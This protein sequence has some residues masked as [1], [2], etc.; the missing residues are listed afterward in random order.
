MLHVILRIQ[1]Q[2]LSLD[3][4]CNHLLVTDLPPDDCL[5]LVLQL[6][7]QLF[8]RNHGLLVHLFGVWHVLVVYF[9]IPH[10]VEDMLQVLLIDLIVFEC[11]V[12]LFVCFIKLVSKLLLLE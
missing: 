8:C 9:W 2:G 12:L 7:H 10:S 11:N 3:D 1:V 6:L 4:L 5:I